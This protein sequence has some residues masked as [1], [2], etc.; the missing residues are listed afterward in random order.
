MEFQRYCLICGEPFRTTECR[1]TCSKVC[2]EEA[3]KQDTW[4][5]EWLLSSAIPQALAVLGLG[6]IDEYPSW[7]KEQRRGKVYFIQAK[8]DADSPIKIGFSKDAEA[9]LIEL[10]VGYPEELCIL[11][12]VDCDPEDEASFHEMFG[13]LRLRGEWFKADVALRNYIALL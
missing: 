6:S 4:Y 2:Q 8:N 12:T 5:A 11:A 1:R 7:K 10:Q 9:R 13:H 3:H